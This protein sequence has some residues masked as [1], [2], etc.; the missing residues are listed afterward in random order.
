MRKRQGAIRAWPRHLWPMAAFLPVFGSQAPAQSV[1]AV[2]DV[3]SKRLKVGT[4]DYTRTRITQEG[5]PA[6][7]IDI[8]TTIKVIFVYS[9]N[10]KEQAVVGP[11]GVLSYSCDSVENAK[12]RKVSGQLKDGI[13]SLEAKQG[14]KNKTAKVKAADYEATTMD[15]VEHLIKEGDAPRR[16]KLLDFDALSVHEETFAFASKEQ[17]TAGGKTWPCR[18]VSFDGPDAK[19][20]RW[21]CEDELGGLIVKEDGQDKDGPYSFTLASYTVRK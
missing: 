4:M 16:I 5:Q 20:K 19:G 1:Q 10:S 7:R 6:T 21:V 17:L 15:T 18:I 2:Y 12:E 14:G 8:T 11:K 13:F 3:H 9:L